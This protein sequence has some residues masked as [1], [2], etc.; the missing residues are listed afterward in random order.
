MLDIKGDGRNVDTIP[1]VLLYF[2][3]FVY[4][5]NEIYNWVSSVIGNG[6]ELQ[7]IFSKTLKA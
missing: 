1:T 4:F 5:K 2:M 6:V 3:H 7:H